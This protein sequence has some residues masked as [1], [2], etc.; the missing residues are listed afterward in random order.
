M[1]KYDN[2]SPTQLD[3]LK[4]RILD[5]QGDVD[6]TMAMYA[7]EAITRLTAEGSPDITV[8]ITSDGGN[9]EAG[10]D[11]YDMLRLYTGKKVGKVI[12]YARSM[13]VMILQ[14]CTERHCATHAR[15]M[16]HHISR[17]SLSLDELRNKKRL[18]VVRSVMEEKQNYLYAILSSRTKRTVKEIKQ[19]CDKNKDMNANQA[20]AFGLVDQII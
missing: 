14:A 4:K 13:A 6:G 19:V 3:L 20:K 1:W 9:T 16:I 11:I 2:L 12:C 10:A 8:I 5:L 7:R 17:N 18:A 15:I